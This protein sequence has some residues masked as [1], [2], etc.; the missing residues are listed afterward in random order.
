MSN[1][2]W[3]Q[4]SLLGACT[5]CFL[6][7]AAGK[8]HAQSLQH[9]IEAEDKPLSTIS[10]VLD[11]AHRVAV[12]E[13]S[14]RCV[15]SSSIIASPVPLNKTPVQ[16]EDV[17]VVLKHLFPD[18]RFGVESDANG[19]ITITQFGMPQDFLDTRIRRIELTREQQYDPTRAVEAVFAT[20]EV[21][22]FMKRNKMSP[23][24]SW[25]GLVS[26]PDQNLPHLNQTIENTTVL[27]AIKA[28]L[29]TFSQSAHLAVYRECSA[30]G[31]R[32][33]SIDFW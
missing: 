6:L 22:D 31:H 29:S 17:V 23:A 10:S 24:N 32:I 27:D 30:D 1:N 13:Y 16:S 2:I 4:L 9:E 20:S 15:K 7:F 25:G 21:R 33:V 28:I 3:N 8:A 5:A 11:K 12:M 18:K 14:G 26:M 19:T